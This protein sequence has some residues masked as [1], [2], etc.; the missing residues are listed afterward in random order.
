MS[1]FPMASRMLCSSDEL[2]AHA[3]AH[4]HTTSKRRVRRL[5]KWNGTNQSHRNDRAIKREGKGRQK[6]DAP[7]YQSHAGPGNSSCRY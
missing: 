1:A 3:N 4:T 2:L 5:A 7:G 6:H